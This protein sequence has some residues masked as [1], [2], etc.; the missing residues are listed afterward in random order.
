MRF[1]LFR[2][3]TLRGYKWYWRLRHQNS[4]VIAQSEGYSRRIDAVEVIRGIREK[5][6]LSNVVD[7]DT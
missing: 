3:L 7:I 1:E 6:H 4:N 2:K 5:A